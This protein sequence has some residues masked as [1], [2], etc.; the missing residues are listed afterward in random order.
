M[1]TRAVKASPGEGSAGGVHNYGGMGALDSQQSAKG[2]N[3]R[4]L[5][6]V[7]GFKFW[8]YQVRPAPRSTQNVHLME[9]M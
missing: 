7:L 5:L 6:Q 2:S 1:W 8:H 9:R 3:P 4:V